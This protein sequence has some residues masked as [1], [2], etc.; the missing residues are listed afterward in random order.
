MLLSIFTPVHDTRFLQETFESVK[1]Q[2]EKGFEWVI[3]PT[4]GVSIP[5]EIASYPQTRV[6]S[7]YAGTSLGEVKRKACDHCEG[8]VL[9]E[10]DSDD[11]LL[12]SA[13]TD[14]RA[15]VLAGGEFI[16]CD[17]VLV[18]PG[19]LDN[20]TYSPRY[21]WEHY[22]F[23]G[24]DKSWRVNRAFDITPTSLRSI[25]YTPDHVRAWTREAYDGS[26]G[27]DSRFSICEDHDLVVRT[28][29]GGYRF[30]GLRDP[31]YMYRMH[32]NNTV[33]KRQH[34]IVEDSLAI[35]R[36]Y[37]LRIAR[38]WCLRNNLQSATTTEQLHKLAGAADNTYGLIYLSSG[39]LNN[40][41]PPEQ[42]ETLE[43][44]YRV[45]VPGGVLA[46]DCD[47]CNLPLQPNN[48][49]QIVDSWQGASEPGAAPLNRFY[50]S[51]LKDQRQPGKVLI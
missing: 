1:R 37:G 15:A 47:H 11:L 6:V 28:Y 30:T 49:F 34:Q 35:G 8:D 40:L 14:I 26:G 50:L 38:Q 13:L 44:A 21:G 33:R 45:L 20:P 2:T 10:L 16:Y 3:V 17:T 5:A 51:A 7:D 29:L 46:G 24:S 41:K 27:Y 23:K 18:G 32:A 42:R 9:V 39:V 36:H 19:D 31:V 25:A 22:D 12:P 48:R 43:T 4:Q